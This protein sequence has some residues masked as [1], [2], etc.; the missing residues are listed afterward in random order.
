M[1]RIECGEAELSGRIVWSMV[2]ALAAAMAWSGPAAA[3]G[4]AEDLAYCGRLIDIYERYIGG[5][6]FGPRQAQPTGDLA[7]KVAV[8]QCRQGDP[9]GIPILE[10]R[11]RANRFT[12]P[13]R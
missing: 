3:Q 4:K 1:H 7:G 8:A 11:L 9:S 12:L 2:A 10:E 5:Y 13:R 6:E